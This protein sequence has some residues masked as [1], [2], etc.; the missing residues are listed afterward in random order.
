MI[1][2]LLLN[3]FIDLN[4]IFVK[5]QKQIFPFLAWEFIPSFLS[6]CY[7]LLSFFSL[8]SLLVAFL[9]AHVVTLA[10]NSSNSIQRERKQLDRK[11][12]DRIIEQSLACARTS[13][14][15]AVLFLL[16]YTC[17]RDLRNSMHS[18]IT[19]SICGVLRWAFSRRRRYSNR[20]WISW[21]RIIRWSCYRI[22]CD[23]AWLANWNDRRISISCIS[24]R[25]SRNLRSLL[26][27]YIRWTQL[28]SLA[29][30]SIGPRTLSRFRSSI[31]QLIN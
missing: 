12:I 21:F 27:A 20:K 16:P 10:L 28:L 8:S 13:F 23:V 2:L 9:L 24:C 22:L 15:F 19:Y 26:H 29:S 4:R 11:T 25:S 1:L 17:G 18:T 31:Y 6:P 30:F 7:V 3:F 5:L 14:T